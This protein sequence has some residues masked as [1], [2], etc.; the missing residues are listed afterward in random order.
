MT[1]LT[2]NKPEN[3]NILAIYHTIATTKLTFSQRF[4]CTI[5]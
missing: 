2:G 1:R 3:C 4:K 5:C